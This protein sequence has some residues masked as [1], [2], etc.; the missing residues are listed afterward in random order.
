[1]LSYSATSNGDRWS[2]NV[3]FSRYDE[4]ERRWSY[5]WSITCDGDVLA[6]ETDLRSG[7]TTHDQPD[8]LGETLATFL[9]FLSAWAEAHERTSDESPG[10]AWDLFPDAALP[11][12]DV[13]TAD[14]L[15]MFADEVSAKF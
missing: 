1:M 4:I 8:R 15:A 14:D 11:V 12:L 6:T 5:T 10:D 13:F 2:F 7:C 9:S 3:D